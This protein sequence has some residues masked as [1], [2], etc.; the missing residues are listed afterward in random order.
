M[1]E[2]KALERKQ[3]KPVTIKEH[4]ANTPHVSGYLHGNVYQIN[5]TSNTSTYQYL[6]TG[7]IRKLKTCNWAGCPLLQRNIHTVCQLTNA[8]GFD[9][10]IL[11]N[12]ME[13]QIHY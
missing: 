9:I 4:Y 10:I 12:T 7:Q 2:A 13:H 11:D 8:T 1:Q 6:S 5:N 3:K